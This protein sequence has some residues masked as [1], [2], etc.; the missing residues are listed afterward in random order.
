MNVF[1]IIGG[2]VLLVISVLLTIV[3]ILQEAHTANGANAL[4]G[5]TEESFYGKNSKSRTQQG[6]LTRWTK[7]AAVAFF[8]I[9][10][11][12]SLCA[13]LLK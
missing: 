7:I 8:V 6:M 4:S 11:V 10:I 9:T 5:M 12:V 1:E 2:I 3:I 13:A